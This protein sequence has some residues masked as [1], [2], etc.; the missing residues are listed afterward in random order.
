MKTSFPFVSVSTASNVHMLHEF[1]IKK[2]KYI[3]IRI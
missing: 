3:R 1:Q 2:K